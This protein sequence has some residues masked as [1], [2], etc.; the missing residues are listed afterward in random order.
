[1]TLKKVNHIIRFIATT[2]HELLGHGTGKLLV[3]TS[4]G[5]YNFDVEH[6]PINSLTNKPV[7]LWYRTGKTW[8]SVFGKL[9]G[10]VEECR[11]MLVSYYLGT[12]KDMLAMYGYDE[13]SEIKAEGRK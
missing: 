7:E 10:T 11:Q 1:M 2:I 6:P 3:E 9:A 12:R 4:P 5:I 8:T 13:D